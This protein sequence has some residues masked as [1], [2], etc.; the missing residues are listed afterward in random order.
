MPSFKIPEFKSIVF[1]SSFFVDVYLIIMSSAFM[2]FIL[3]TDISKDS[4]YTGLVTAV[5]AV[6]M[7][8]TFVASIIRFMI[9]LMVRNLYGKKDSRNKKA[10]VSICISY[11]Y[12]AFIVIASAVYV[13]YILRNLS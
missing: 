7:L 6:F 12:T 3:N 13:E 1:S 4:V 2:Y 8:I 9:Y 10:F 5:F 11:A